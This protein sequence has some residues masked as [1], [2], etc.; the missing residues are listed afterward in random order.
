MSAVETAAEMP[1]GST[2]LSIAEELHM[3]NSI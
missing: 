1:P 2:V 3:R